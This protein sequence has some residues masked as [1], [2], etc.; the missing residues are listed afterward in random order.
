MC[1]IVIVPVIGV[2]KVDSNKEKVDTKQVDTKQNDLE[3]WTPKQA[4]NINTPQDRIFYN[5]SK[6]CSHQYSLVCTSCGGSLHF[7]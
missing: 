3:S 1:V 5:P 2:G 7:T 4:I 6:L